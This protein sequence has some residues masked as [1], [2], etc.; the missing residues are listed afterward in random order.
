MDISM[1]TGQFPP[2]ESLVVMATWAVIFGW[3]SVRMFKWEYDSH[4]AAARLS[5]LR[6]W[7]KRQETRTK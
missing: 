5:A 3:L 6:E 2:A 1:L 7:G 4:A